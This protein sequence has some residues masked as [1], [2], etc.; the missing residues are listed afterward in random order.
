MMGVLVPMQNSYDF[1]GFGFMVHRILIGFGL[2]RVLVQNE[3]RG[4]TRTQ[5]DYVFLM[6]VA[7]SIVAYTLLW[8][9]WE[10]FVNRLGMAYDMIGLYFL[11]RLLLRSPDEVQSAIR[12]LASLCCILA[13]AM[14][15][16]FITRR[17]VFSAFG[18]A[19]EEVWTRMDTLRCRG[20]FRHALSAGVFGASLLPLW[21]MG[22]K[23]DSVI[24]VPMAIAA[25]IA[26]T[27]MTVTSASSSSVMTFA[28]GLCASA[29]WF[30]RSHLRAIRW[31][32]V[33]T[34]C[35]LH[36]VMKAPVW[37]LMARVN[38]F[39]GSTGYHRYWLFDEFVK[40]F[41]EWWLL[42][43]KS[44]AEWDEYGLLWDVVNQ[45][46]LEGV[47]GGVLKLGLF[48]ALLALLFR[49]VGRMVRQPDASDSYARLAW[50]LGCVLFAQC[51]A[52]WAYNFWDQIIIP[53]Y[54]LLALIA[55]LRTHFL[56]EN[57]TLPNESSEDIQPLP[58]SQPCEGVRVHS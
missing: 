36:L 23:R 44:T 31:A 26:S 21:L 48:I 53:W 24:G 55:G 11:F 16:E 47:R 50:G 49:E 30:Y 57:E 28:A 3:G 34:L 25:A 32:V 22:L 52:F 43:T 51:V 19:D 10:A 15:V 7:W 39:G 40:R 1:M 4:F 14:M 54:L 8:G 27:I 33:L 58:T 2:L 17:N 5:I 9:T 46:V 13:V 37:A 56:S 12:G 29:M 45:Y 6:L 20:S 38:V 18:G 41:S 35:G 42:G